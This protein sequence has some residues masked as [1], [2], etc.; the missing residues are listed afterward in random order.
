MKHVPY[1]EVPAVQVDVPGA[2]KCVVRWLISNDD[3]APNFYMRRFELSPGGM[4]PLHTHPWEHEVYVLEGQGTLH[5]GG[6]EEP[7]QAGEVIFVPPDDEH[8]FRAGGGR[9]LAF[10][11]VIPKAGKQVL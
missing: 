3:G 10:L 8:Q 2:S 1:E 6:L 5:C 7:F 9:G 4:T 11:C